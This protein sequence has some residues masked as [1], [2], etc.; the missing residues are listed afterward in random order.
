[1]NKQLIF[2]NAWNLVK[3]AG[4]KFRDALS[5]AWALASKKANTIYKIVFKK[6]S[7]NTIT[8]R[9]LK[10]QT[11]N[12]KGNLMFYSIDDDGIRSTKLGNIKHFSKTA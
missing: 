9:L 2:E 3:T 7:D 1:M 12:S 6:E 8:E 5:L 11:I 10:E 4:M